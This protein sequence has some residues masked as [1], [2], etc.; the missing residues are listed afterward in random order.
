MSE[1]D[2]ER[3]LTQNFEPLGEN[4]MKRKG[5]HQGLVNVRSSSARPSDAYVSVFYRGRWYYIADDDARSKAYFVLVG[6]IFSLQ[7]GELHTAQP[8]LT[9]PVNQ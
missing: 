1:K 8:L 5:L 6:M 4:M 3:G 2:V 7:A 9:L